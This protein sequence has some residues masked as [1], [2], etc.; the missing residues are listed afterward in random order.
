MIVLLCSGNNVM[1]LKS[2]K[3][4]VGLSLALSGSYIKNIVFSDGQIF[5]KEEIC[6]VLIKDYW[7]EE[8]DLIVRTY[9]QLNYRTLISTLSPII[10]SRI[11]NKG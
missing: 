5:P 11:S 2:G 10:R 4:V 6:L 3:V 9:D 8:V 7:I 1:R